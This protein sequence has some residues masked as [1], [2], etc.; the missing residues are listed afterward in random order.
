M[1]AA[2]FHIHLNVKVNRLKN[3]W[4]WLLAAAVLIL[5]FC[6]RPLNSPF[7]RIIAADGLGYYAYLPAQFIHQ[8][9]DL[10]FTWFDDVFNRHYDNH[11]FAKPSDNFI[12]Q[13]HGKGINKYYPGQSFLQLPFFFLAHVFAKL[14]NYPAD[15]FSLPYQ[16]GMGLAALFYSLVGL[17]FCSRL[18]SAIFVDRPQ[19]S[20]TIPIVIFFGT[21]LFTQTIFSGCYSHVYSFCAITLAFYCAYLFFNTGRQ[22]TISFLS[23]V[24]FCCLAVTIR[25]MNIILLPGLIY[26]FKPFQFKD[27]QFGAKIIWHATVLIA[28]SIATIYY[29]ANIIIKQTGVLF[30]DTY[31]GEKFYFTAWNHVVNNLFGFQHS[32]LWYTPLILICFVAL[33][34]V[35]K[36][37]SI[38][39]LIFPFLL[40]ILLYSFWWYWNILARVIV[41]CSVILA[42]LMGHALVYLSS[43]QRLYRAALM[44]VFVSVPFFQLKA[45]Q[46]REHIIDSNYTYAKYYFKHFFTVRPIAVFPVNPK[47][48]VRQQAFFQDFESQQGNQIST[49]FKFEGQQSAVLDSINEYACTQTFYVPHFFSNKGF[50]KIKASFWMFATKKIENVTFVFTVARKDSSL[51]YL[52][53]YMLGNLRKEKWDFREYGIDA[54]DMIKPGDQLTVYFWNPAHKAAAYIDNLKIEFLLT[55]GSDEMAL[56]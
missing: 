36:R 24:F 46:L 18:L 8:D 35:K 22:K 40:V 43:Y 2:F 25:P 6:L 48:V 47:T 33:F 53:F 49:N 30:A 12:V 44:C 51:A 32:I 3:S 27:F 14:L 45:F 55:D 5:F 20:I 34:A 26:F 56:R 50:K 38:L 15:G 39:F 7:Y 37:P 16:I 54:P 42:L 29:S 11:L 41:D 4:F 19:L 31:P 17:F 10:S 13:F 1:W 52:P 21:N 28:L 9:N 23:T